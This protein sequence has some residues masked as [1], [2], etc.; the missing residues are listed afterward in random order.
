MHQYWAWLSVMVDGHP[1]KG[2][3]HSWIPP[4]LRLHKNTKMTA[5]H[6]NRCDDLSIFCSSLLSIFTILAQMEITN[7]S[8]FLVFAGMF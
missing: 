5:L 7:L 1:R 2:E 4:L 6:T 8:A 3:A